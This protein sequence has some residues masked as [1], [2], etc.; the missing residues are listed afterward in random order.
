MLPIFFSLIVLFPYGKNLRKMK[1]WFSVFN[2]V[3]P[4]LVKG[5]IEINVTS[6]WLSGEESTCL[7][8]QTSTATMED[9]VESP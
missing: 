3:H 9:S 1:I 2:Y 7:G 5:Y 8:M 6:W 4:S